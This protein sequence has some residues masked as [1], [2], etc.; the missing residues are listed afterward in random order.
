M[1]RNKRARGTD[2]N[3]LNIQKLR[4]KRTDEASELT[5]KKSVG[6]GLL[7]MGGA[8]EQGIE[9]VKRMVQVKDLN[10]MCLVETHIRK[11]DKEGIVIPGFQTHECGRE[12][13]EKKGGGLAILTRK[14]DVVFSRHHWQ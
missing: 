3:R 12:G 13:F 9:D 2:S 11:E 1:K 10:I 8:S 14:G 6:I 7:N 5:R 4:R